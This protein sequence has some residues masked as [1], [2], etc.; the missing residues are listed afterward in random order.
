MLGIQAPLQTVLF[1]N[2]IN[3]YYYTTCSSYSTIII[4]FHF[5]PPLVLLT[6][7]IWK[8]TLSLSENKGMERIEMKILWIVLAAFMPDKRTFMRCLC[9][10]QLWWWK[11]TSKPSLHEDKLYSCSGMGIVICTDSSLDLSAQKSRVWKS[12]YHCKQFNSNLDGIFYNMVRKMVSRKDGKR[13][14][15]RR[16]LCTVKT[17]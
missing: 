10:I 16:K 9:K 1:S 3:M 5:I 7:H 2:N 15:K 13:Q 12:A 8:G 6:I 4:F 17:S 14:E 11:C